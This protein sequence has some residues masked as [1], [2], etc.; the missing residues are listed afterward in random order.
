MDPSDHGP[1]GGAWLQKD[2]HDSAPSTNEKLLRTRLVFG[3]GSGEMICR[4][5]SKKGKAPTSNNLG[6][7]LGDE[8]ETH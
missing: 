5:S 6:Q 3:C 1:S 8:G 4:G 7:G 2:G